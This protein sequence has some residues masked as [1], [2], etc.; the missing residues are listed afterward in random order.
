MPRGHVMS[1]PWH[2]GVLSPAAPEG[3]THCLG[4]GL[5]SSVAGTKDALGTMPLLERNGLV[6]KVR[7]DP[8]DHVILALLLLHPRSL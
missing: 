4:P 1:G 7:Q 2:G 8:G 6:S 3:S 5:W